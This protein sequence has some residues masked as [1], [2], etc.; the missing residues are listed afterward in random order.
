[1]KAMIMAA[2]LGTRLKPLTD[3]RPKAMIEIEGTPLLGR[4][5]EN[6]K[7]QGADKVIVNVHHFAEQVI[8]YVK[9]KHWGLDVLISDEREDLVDT[10]G[11]LSKAFNLIF[12]ND[13]RPVLVH[14]VD[15][16]SNANL[17]NLYY[18]VLGKDES[19]LLVSERQS[20]RK[21]IFSPDMHLK[22]WHHLEKEEFLPVSYV[23]EP[24][25]REFAFSG[26]YCLTKDAVAEMKNM[27]GT[28]KYSVIEY[29]LNP[30]RKEKLRGVEQ[31]LLK[32]LDIGK[33]A[34]L[35]QAPVFI[36]DIK[37]I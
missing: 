14:N 15:I 28:N 5:I 20:T 29:F 31:P 9:E 1:M 30:E 27:L 37:L 26:I 19:T 3:T 11:G 36:K 18:N 16:I 35:L 12:E 21:L 7:N 4:L 32:L 33:P 22:G 34:A 25:D 6:L 23:K 13:E 24:T 10:G 8:N 17:K 2:G